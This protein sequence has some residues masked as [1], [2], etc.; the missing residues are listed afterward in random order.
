MHFLEILS[1]GLAE[2]QLANNVAQSSKWDPLLWEKLEATF[3][4][5]K[6]GDT[7]FKE[8]IKQGAPIELLS[9]SATLRMNQHN[10][11]FGEL[12]SDGQRNLSN[13]SV[14]KNY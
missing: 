10:I 9:D 12:H 1:V 4:R 2:F 14:I 5:D 3:V 6:M 13:F 7:S 11:L 8:S